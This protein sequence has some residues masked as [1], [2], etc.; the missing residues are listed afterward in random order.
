MKERDWKPVRNGDVYCSPACGYGCTW[1]AFTEATRAS[2][3]LAKQLGPA[4][5]PRVWD[6]LGWW[7]EVRVAGLNVSLDGA[8]EWMALF[9]AHSAHAK[10]AKGAIRSVLRRATADLKELQDALNP[11]R[12]SYTAPNL[13]NGEF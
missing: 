1:A 6:N 4:W 7:W 13:L 11:H 3:K 10:T 8:G 5:E 12:V 9:G 2:A